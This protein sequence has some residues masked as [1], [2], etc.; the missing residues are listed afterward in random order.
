[1]ISSLRSLERE[2]DGKWKRGNG[3]VS[4]FVFVE[5]GGP[6]RPGVIEGST[7]RCTAAGST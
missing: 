6:D 2:K 3:I 1:M 7:S 5:K 4:F